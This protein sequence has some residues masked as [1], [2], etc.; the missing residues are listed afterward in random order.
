MAIQGTQSTLL[1]LTDASAARPLPLPVAQRIEL[2]RPDAVHL[3]VQ[4]VKDRQGRIGP[5]HLVPYRV[6]GVRSS[7]GLSKI[8]PGKIE[9]TPSRARD[10]VQRL[11]H[12]H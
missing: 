11:V 7:P 3:K 12:A 6:A 1:L 10:R 4:V 9:G 8:E 2:S 5:P